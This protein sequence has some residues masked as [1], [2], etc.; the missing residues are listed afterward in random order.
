MAYNNPRR[1][2]FINNIT[3]NMGLGKNDHFEIYSSV[4]GNPPLRIPVSVCKG[5]SN[6]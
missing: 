6:Y 5:Y 1:E 4:E 2:R 3:I